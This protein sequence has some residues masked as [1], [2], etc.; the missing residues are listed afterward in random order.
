[1]TTTAYRL[2]ASLLVVTFCLLPR[3]EIAAQEPEPT[4]GRAAPLV[5]PEGGRWYNANLIPDG[6]AESPYT[7]RWVD[8]EGF[9][10]IV[11]YGQS[12]GGICSFP[13]P[14]DPGPVQR[15]TRFFYM[16]TTSNH[17]NGT[18]MWIKDK[19]DLAPIQSAIHTGQVRY[20]L[21]GYFGGDTNNPNT[22]QL[23]MFFET[24]AGSS[25]GEVVVGDVTPAE[26]LNKTGL[27]YREKTGFVPAGTQQINLL[28]QSGTIIDSDY[29]TGYA[30]N[31]SLVLL[32][33][34]TFLPLVT[35]GPGSQT[36]PQTGLPAPS[37]V[38][39]TPNGLTRMDVYWTDNS[40][41]ELGFE[42]LRVNPDA[43][44]DT[45]CNT[46]S[47]VTYCFDPGI[48]QH[49]AYGYIYLG[50]QV[51]YT[52]QVRAVG[53]GINSAWASGG[54]TTAQMPLT[55]PSPLAGSSFTCQAIET[56]SSSTTF[57]WNNPFNYH[58]GFNLYL[59]GNTYPSWSMLENGAKITFINQSPGTIMLRIVPFVYDRTNPS[60]VYESATSCTA[61]ANLPSPPSSGITRFYDNASY[62][63]ISLTV[64]G[65]EQFPVRPLG[66]LPGAYYELEGVP[67]G[68]HSWTAVTGFWDDEG[69]RFAMYEY[70]G[71][72]TQSGSGPIHVSIPDMT[73]QDLLTVPPA[74]LGYWEGYYF[75]QNANCW[76]TAFKFKQDG[77]YTFY[78]ANSP[79]NSGT[80]SLVEREPAIFSTVFHVSGGQSAD[81]L[82]VETRGQ[83]TMKNGPA[84]WNQIT[85]VYKPQGYVRN[86]FC[87]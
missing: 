53:E 32:P 30:D 86:P 22:A 73:I 17:Y 28:L 27:L 85:Y 74:N 81:G 38:T 45:I 80:Y 16:G 44:V 87:P 67:S 57:V 78:N 43:T 49:A 72:Y 48:S 76:T 59:G 6:D 69:R 4:A 64:D 25:N 20:I 82:L 46:K 9:M 77:T 3:Q 7:T 24:G 33:V 84:S 39:A 19:I 10:Q 2:L 63:V 12:C 61:T 41:A 42:V 5:A 66:I 18:N 83:F 79:V 8:N 55:P 13:T 75:D 35:R 37:G 47:N 31:L 26:R 29:R 51:H 23:H 62:P 56:T 71:S 34:R 50:N 52:Y 11:P 40:P 58:A 65:W 60:T 54:G 1:M 68:L 15:G 36:P 21:S 14:Y 70:T